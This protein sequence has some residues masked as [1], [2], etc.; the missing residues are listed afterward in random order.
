MVFHI[1]NIP[2]TRTVFHP[3]PL[4]TF[5][6]FEIQCSQTLTYRMK[7]KKQVLEEERVR[8]MRSRETSSEQGSTGT[9]VFRFI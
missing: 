4:L 9:I 5:S 7:W 8:K 6:A 1:Q 2:S 3:R